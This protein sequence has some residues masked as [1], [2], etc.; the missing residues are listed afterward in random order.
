MTGYVLDLVNLLSV[1]TNKDF[2]LIVMF[3][4]VSI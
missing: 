3:L 1:Y 4:W 2:S